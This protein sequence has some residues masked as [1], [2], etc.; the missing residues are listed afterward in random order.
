MA[1]PV[2][3]VV[4]RTVGGNGLQL[5]VQPR[6]S[7]RDIQ[8][9]LCRHFGRPFPA[10]KAT[11]IVGDRSFTEFDDKPFLL[12]AT[13]ATVVFVQTDDPYFYDLRDRRP[14]RFPG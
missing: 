13:E 7:L 11:L 5:E 12:G 2:V 6:T 9:D 10:T 3:H 8:F 14:A 1:T 4:V